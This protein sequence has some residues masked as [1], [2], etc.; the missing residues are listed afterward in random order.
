MVRKHPT[1]MDAFLDVSGVG[2]TKQEQYGQVFL[3]VIRDGREPNDAML[4][5]HVVKRTKLTKENQ[6]SAWSAEEEGRLKEEYESELSMREIAQKHQRSVGGIK[7][8]LQKL[9]LIE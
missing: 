9:G 6:G 2:L 5:F 8:R 7:A 1:S 3:A 4:D